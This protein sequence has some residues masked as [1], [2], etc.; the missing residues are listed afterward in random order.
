MM[1][2]CVSLQWF[3]VSLWSF[4]VSPMFECSETREIHLGPLSL[5]LVGPKSPDGQKE[6]HPVQ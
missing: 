1:P 5:R 3:Y 6:K 4:Y 2:L